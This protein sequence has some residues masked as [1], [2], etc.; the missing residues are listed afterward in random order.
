M[1]CV[2][3]CSLCAMFQYSLGRTVN[4][5]VVS[6]LNYAAYSIAFKYR[7]QAYWLLL[8]MI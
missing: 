3:V 7:Y 1:Q 4:L 6:L 5:T 8:N 2:C